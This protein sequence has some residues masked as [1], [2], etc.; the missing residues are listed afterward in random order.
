MSNRTTRRRGGAPRR[1]R[2]HAASALVLIVSLALAVTFALISEASYNHTENRLLAID[3]K[4]TASTLEAVPLYVEAHL[5]ATANLVEGAT[6]PGQDFVHA[7]SPIVGTAKTASFSAASLWHVS[8]G[9]AHLVARVGAA[10]LLAPSSPTTQRFILHAPSS[11]FDVQRLTAPGAVRLGY[12]IAAGVRHN[13]V[14]YAEEPLPASGTIT[15]PPTSPISELNVALYLGRS[16]R[17]GILLETDALHSLPLRGRV[18]TNTIPFGDKVLTLVL[19]PHGSL[20]GALSESVP[21]GVGIAIALIGIAIALVVERLVRRRDRAERSARESRRQLETQREIAHTL[22]QSLLPDRLPDCPEISFAVRYL[23]GG[24]GVE[25][26]GDW[27]D[28][29]EVD[30]DHLF[31]TLGDVSGRGVRAA[32]LMGTL[33]NALNAYALEGHDPGTALGLLAP[34]V[35]VRDGRFATVLCGR[36]DRRSG[37]VELANAGHLPPLV[38]R[39]GG[40]ELLETPVGPPVGVRAG[41]YETTRLELAPGE[42][43]LG[44]TDGLVERRGEILTAGLE[45]LRRATAPHA[46]LDAMVDRALEALGARQAADDIAILAV[47]R[48]AAPAAGPAGTT[49]SATDRRASCEAADDTGHPSRRPEGGSSA[50][51]GPV[52]H[53]PALGG[54]HSGHRR[55]QPTHTRHRAGPGE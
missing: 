46:D 34:L 14:V 19:S 15:E 36:I 33:R 22:Q 35:T 1:R 28:V 7:I 20:S 53:T 21:F 16:V 9:R 44:Y 24:E 50:S 18:T 23:A 31:F 10:P 6:H 12:A 48:Q 49:G 39:P 51:S 42:S 54:G 11:T 8:H 5:A 45:R 47:R 43:L 30:A 38:I 17:R 37:E 4:L 25:V 26:G 27:Y 13:Y 52:L 40:A 2:I 3:G 29:V 32:T 55:R 41:R